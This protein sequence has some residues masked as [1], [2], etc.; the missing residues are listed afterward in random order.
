MPWALRRLVVRSS[1]RRAIAYLLLAEGAED[2][3]LVYAV[4]ELG[5][6]GVFEDLHHVVLELLEG[7]ITP[8]VG[9]YLCAPMLEV[10]I[11]TVA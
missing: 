4:D 8:G 11:V 7:L 5:A 6:K 3:D 9:L 1:R 2:D 10:M